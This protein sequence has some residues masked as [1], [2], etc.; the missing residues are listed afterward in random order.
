MHSAFTA[1]NYWT[2]RLAEIGGPGAELR[3][4]ETVD[5]QFRVEMIQVVAEKYLPPL[6]SRIRR[7]DLKIN[8]TE[9]WGPLIDNRATGS[10]TVDVSGAPGKIS[11]SLTLAASGSG[12]VLTVD[13]DVSVSVPL[14]G[15]RIEEAIV[16]QLK[17][18]MRK[19]DDFTEAWTAAHS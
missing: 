13:G 3:K 5:G 6:V 4:V 15:G 11:G 9:A 19:E 7:G 8:R 10:F 18:L 17:R 12:S 14:F 1:K 16:E 2:D